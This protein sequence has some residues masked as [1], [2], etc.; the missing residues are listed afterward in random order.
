MN[1]LMNCIFTP[2][3]KVY[4]WFFPFQNL[5]WSVNLEYLHSLLVTNVTLCALMSSQIILFVFYIINRH[6]VKI[7]TKI[8]LCLVQRT[9]QSLIFKF[10]AFFLQFLDNYAFSLKWSISNLCFEDIFTKSTGYLM[11]RWVMEKVVWL[12]SIM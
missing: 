10:S 5:L 11:N 2:S 1:E 7:L 12:W 3:I 8:F 9:F 4:C 6:H